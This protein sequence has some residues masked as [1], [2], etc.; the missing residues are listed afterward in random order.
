M[1]PSFSSMMFSALLGTLVVAAVLIGGILLL[2]RTLASGGGSAASAG[3]MT[4]PVP[5]ILLVTA[6]GMP[7]R[8]ALYHMA[9]LTGVVSAEGIDAVAVR[10]SG[11]IASAKWP[12]PGQSLPVIVD[13]ADPQRFTIEW[14]KVQTTAD[15]AM[16]QAVAIAAA[17]RARSDQ[18]H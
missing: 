11:L 8:P 2:T 13:R 3:S 6:I 7:R 14:D 4:D 10:H 12:R 9:R 16:D 17:M 1:L 18:P 15:A 5:G